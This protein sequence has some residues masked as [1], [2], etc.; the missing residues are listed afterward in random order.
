MKRC[1]TPI[2][3]REGSVN[4]SMCLEVDVAS[5]GATETIARHNLVEVFALFLGNASDEEADRRLR[6]EFNV[7]PI[8]IEVA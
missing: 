4:V 7:D 3:E 6:G 2:V 5:P 1:S 8:E